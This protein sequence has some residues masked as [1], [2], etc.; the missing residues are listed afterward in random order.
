MAPS[1][2]PRPPTRTGLRQQSPA[3]ASG[4]LLWPVVLVDVVDLGSTPIEM[5]H[6]DDCL[7]EVIYHIQIEEV[8]VFS[9]FFATDTQFLIN[10][11][12]ISLLTI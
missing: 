3:S 10:F 5:E 7:L 12:E 1:R 8:G 6:V 4:L 2:P 9:P 11:M